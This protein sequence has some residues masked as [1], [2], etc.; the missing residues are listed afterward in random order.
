MFGLAALLFV[1]AMASTKSSFLICFLKGATNVMSVAVNRTDD[2]LVALLGEERPKQKEKKSRVCLVLTI[3]AGVVLVALLL[4]ILLVLSRAPSIYKWELRHISIPLSNGQTV[5]A[6]LAF[7]LTK[8]K[9]Q[10]MQF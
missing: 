9:V 7:P 4:V 5:A 6:S 1:C 3:I 8:N 2:D 10:V